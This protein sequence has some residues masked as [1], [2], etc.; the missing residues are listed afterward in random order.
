MDCPECDVAQPSHARFCGHCGAR[1]VDAFPAGRDRPPARRGR[2][3]IAAALV[4]VGAVATT[5]ATVGS[6]SVPDVGRDAP[7]GVVLPTDPVAPPTEGASTPPG[8]LPVLR[9]LPTGPG[10][11]RA[12]SATSISCSRWSV[13]SLQAVLGRPTVA[14]RQVLVGA[15][16]SVAALRTETGE[17]L[18][19]TGLPHAL[20]AAPAADGDVVVVVDVGGVVT[21]L[22]RGTGGILWRHPFGEAGVRVAVTDDFVVV[23]RPSGAVMGLA[24]DDGASVWSVPVSG[25]PSPPVTDGTTVFVGDG[26]GQ[27]RAISLTDGDVRWTGDADGWEVALADR[28]RVLAV[29]GFGG[30]LLGLDP[31]TGDQLWASDIGVGWAT[32]HPLPD[33][34]VLVQ[35]GGRLQRIDASDGTSRSLVAQTLEQNMVVGSDGLVYRWTRASRVDVIDPEGTAVWSD[36]TSRALHEMAVGRAVSSPWLVATLGRQPTTLAGTLAP[37]RPPPDTIVSVPEDGPCPT[38]PVIDRPYRQVAAATHTEVAGLGTDGDDAV[39]LVMDLSETRDALTISGRQLDGPGRMGFR[40]GH[41]EPPHATLT[42]S[43]NGRRSAPGWPPHWGI[44]AS[45]SAP[46]CWS[47]EITHDTGHT[48]QIV[49]EIAPDDFEA[50]TTEARHEPHELQ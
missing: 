3:Q 14:G 10:T 41:D 2:W 28:N 7:S 1:L 23:A 45:V 44:V 39:T 49:V 24:R 33:G 37:A 48:D 13:E 18:W 40:L 43:S 26:N 15:G 25:R 6:V 38:S 8:P 16:A 21:A 32:P 19:Q 5:V 31:Q 42:L 30:P 20:E 34:A 17:M 36:D 9:S 22:D 47:Y 46:G 27:V 4:V 11:C 12:E 50:L 29:S 35:A